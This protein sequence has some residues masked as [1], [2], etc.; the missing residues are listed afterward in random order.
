MQADLCN[1]VSGCVKESV[2]GTIPGLLGEKNFSVQEERSGGST[3]EILELKGL[4]WIV[5]STDFLHHRRALSAL[6]T[7]H[8][9]Y[10]ERRREGRCAV[11][12]HVPAE[13]FNGVKTNGRPWPQEKKGVWCRRWRLHPCTPYRPIRRCVGVS[14]FL[15]RLLRFPPPDPTHIREPFLVEVGGKSFGST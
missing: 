13:R 10:E 11:E 5:P 4:R 9:S 8:L 12:K 6:S 14:F 1:M 15:L 3:G 2:V 7:V